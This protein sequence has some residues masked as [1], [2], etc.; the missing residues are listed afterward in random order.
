MSS[1]DL[2]TP[3][4]PVDKQHRIFSYLLAPEHQ[5]EREVLCQW[6]SGF[7]DRDKKFVKE[8]QTTFE[9]SM[10][11]LYVFAYLKE[12]GADVDFSHATPD[13]VVDLHSQ[14]CIEATV[15]APAQGTPSPFGEF[16]SD[17]L[18]K[19]LNDF[20]SQATLRICNRLDAKMTKYREGYA[21]LEHVSEKPFVLA[22]ASFDRPSSYMEG[23]R[24]IMAA[25]YGI[26]WDE[27]ATRHAQTPFIVRYPV[28]TVK[29]NKSTC[30]PLG[31]FT[32]DRYHELSAVIYNPL[33]TWGKIRALAD[34]PAASSVYTTFHTQE[35]RI[36]PEIRNSLKK[37]YSEHLLDGCFVFHNPHASRPLNREPLHHERIA[38]V[39]MTESGELQSNEPDDF[40][41]MRLIHS[42][43]HTGS[44]LF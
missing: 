16:S 17:I 11:E 27:E 36:A 5:P 8:F 3:V 14:F 24:P 20:N 15:A 40:L 29:K 34:S 37:D 10:W 43:R 9:S 21:S 4:V 22:L 38:Q 6:A 33:A 12:L 30:I 1:M 28:E 13:F 25:L 7:V 44:T 19:D 42:L 23:S 39:W 41:L 32:D 18:P 35:G 31:L 2:F 26:Y